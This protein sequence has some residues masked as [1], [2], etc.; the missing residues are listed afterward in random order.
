MKKSMSV[1]ILTALGGLTLLA[2]SAGLAAEAFFGVQ[3]TAAVTQLLAS[4]HVLAVLVKLVLTLALAALAVATVICAMPRR[5]REQD[6]YVMQRGENGAIGISVK[7]IEKQVRACVAK[8]DVIAEAEVSIRECRDGLII[9]LNVDQV[10]GV[11]IPLSVGLLQKQIKQYVSGCTGVDVHEVRVMVENNTTNVV[12]S[13]FAVQEA[14]GP[15]AVRPA[16]EYRT[17]EAAEDQSAPAAPA[18]D[19]PAETAAPAPAPAAAVPVVLPEIPPM[20]AVPASDEE[21]D[22]RPLHQRIF[23]AEEQPVFV[24][25]PPELLAEQPDDA[26]AEEAEETV[27]EPEAEAE[28]VV[29]ETELVID[30]GDDAAEAG[31]AYSEELWTDDEELIAGDAAVVEFIAGPDED[32]QADAEDEAEEPQLLL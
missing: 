31:A 4:G 6:G 21:E 30:M 27:A 29:E 8:H 17:V 20:P 7:A 3:V 11:N 32:E 9:L 24:P 18:A 19:T 10:A 1:R 23:G 15:Q 25:A 5:R 12:A 28:P 22:E 26:E 14:A 13:P 16:E 2:L